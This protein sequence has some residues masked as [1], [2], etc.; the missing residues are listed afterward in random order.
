MRILVVSNLYPP[1]VIGGYELL[2][3]DAVEA[4]RRRGHEVTVLTS[5]PRST[6]IDSDPGHVER[7]LAMPEVW[8][9]RVFGGLD[10]TTRSAEWSRAAWVNPHNVHQLLDSIGRLRPDVVYL[11]NLLG[12]GGLAIAATTASTG[13]PWVWHLMDA[14]P[15]AICSVDGRL[16]P[17]LA[18]EL[19]TRMD[20]RYIAVSDH[21]FGELAERGVEVKGSR[22]VLPVWIS[23]ARRPL[24][25]RWYRGGHLRIAFAAQLSRPKGTPLLIEA[26]RMVRTAGYD[27]FSIDLFGR[28]L[29]D[30]Y[31]AMIAEHGVEKQVRICGLRP[32]D[33]LS[34]EYSAY[35]LFCLPTLQREPFACAPLEAAAYG[36]VPVFT[37]DCGDAEWLVDGVH[38]IKLERSAEA[39]ARV[40]VAVLRGDL[41]LEPIGRR[42]AAMVRD[43]FH[44]DR[45]VV[46]IELELT[47]AARTGRAAPRVDG[48]RV[49]RLAIL[50]DR[51]AR[52]LAQDVAGHRVEER[53]R[54]LEAE[55]SRAQQAAQREIDR[56]EA[57][58]AGIHVGYT[59]EIE[60]LNR[61]IAALHARYSAEVSVLIE[62]L[63]SLAGTDVA[64]DPRRSD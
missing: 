11:W 22:T 63:G 23:G 41:D 51:A 21:L 52:Q 7:R 3:G 35:D 64:T 38:C 46:D 42:A 31:A 53:V 6:P 9:A 45:V 13:I 34:E 33:E 14:V 57:E 39:Y 50:L 58:I 25:R 15:I 20:G 54:R 61:E 10:V 19:S 27:D 59:R 12:I 60:R 49:Q 47:E 2:C 28:A 26:A 62:R 4:L 17:A 55:L 48:R 37:H 16:V 1:D 32:R 8:D 30:D 56:L 43:Q 24:Q 36:C 18:R 5:S 44:V 40:I 29:D